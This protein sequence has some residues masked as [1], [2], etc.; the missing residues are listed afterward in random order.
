MLFIGN[1]NRKTE[2]NSIYVANSDGTD[3]RKVLTD[4]GL[5]TE[6]VFSDCENKIYYIKSREYGHSSPLGRDQAHDSDLYAVDLSNGE[7]ERVTHLHAYSVYGVSEYRCNDIMIFM[8]YNQMPGLLMLSKNKPDS[9][10]SINP[11]NDPRNDSSLYY[12]PLYS[13]KYD[14]LGFTAPYELYIMNMKI[15]KASLVTYS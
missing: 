4:D 7:V 10:I 14:V 2:G 13:K 11:L 9:L 1:K 12:S 8:P 3:R 15:K 6:A 5:I